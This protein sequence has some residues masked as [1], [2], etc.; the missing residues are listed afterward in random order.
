MLICRP[1]LKCNHLSNQ[2]LFLI[3]L[4]YLLNL[5]QILNILKK[6]TIAIPTLFRKLENVK[7]LVRPLSK[8][9]LFRNSFKNQ[10][11]KQSQTLVKY[12]SEHFHHLF[13]LLWETLMWKIA[14]LV[15]W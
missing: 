7:N 3:F 13:L 5:N 10:H 15:I 6:K 12:A 8:K 11:V 2:Q 1:Q 4:F 9:Y 14:P